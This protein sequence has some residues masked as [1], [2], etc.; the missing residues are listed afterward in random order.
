MTINYPVPVLVQQCLDDSSVRTNMTKHFVN[1][2]KNG[3]NNITAIY[4]NGSKHGG[5]IGNDV[6]YLAKDNTT[7]SVRESSVEM[8]KFITNIENT[9]T[10]K[11]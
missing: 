3:S 11:K 9:I 6:T 4:Y 1:S 7:L 2:V 10:D 8:S 5:D